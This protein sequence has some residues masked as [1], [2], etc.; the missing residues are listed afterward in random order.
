MKVL[1]INKFHYM[2]GGSETYYF[3][4]A[5][6]LKAKG[7][8]VIFFSMDDE[9]NVP[10]AQNKY[11]APNVEYVDQQ[12]FF[13][14]VKAVKNFVYSTKAAQKM[15]ELI[16][17]E[18]PDVAHIGLLHRQITFSVVSVLKKHNIPIVMTMHD[19]IFACPCYTMLVN[20]KPCEDC[21]D[22]SVL[23]C[24]KKKCIKN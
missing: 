10:C 7:H 15:E 18:H 21:V 16:E 20:G 11:F 1:L 19:L 4:Q 6:A 23:N 2:K 13:N 9:R 22:G 5:D 12:G 14:K 17:S 3:G 8:E 24:V